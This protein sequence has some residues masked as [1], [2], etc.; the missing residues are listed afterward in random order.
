MALRDIP[1]TN[2]YL[3]FYDDELA[4]NLQRLAPAARAAFA[5]AC[6][7]RSLDHVRWAGEKEAAKELRAAI[8]S[9]WQV[10]NGDV[11]RETLRFRKRA[12]EAFVPDP[13]EN[14]N[15]AAAH[16]AGCSVL[17]AIDCVL[18]AGDAGEAMHAAEE[19]YAPWQIRAVQPDRTMTHT[20][21]QELESESETCQ[22]E[23]AFQRWL[24]RALQENSAMGREDL[25]RFAP[26]EG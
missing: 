4:P 8:D 13:D 19:A 17:A 24:L 12:L 10:V 5:L 16:R 26:S 14:A 21:L 2:S 1:V 25:L 18:S 6:A 7:E 9:A 20:Q 11:A 23:I 15:A 3:Q 22:N